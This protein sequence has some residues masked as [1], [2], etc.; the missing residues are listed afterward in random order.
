[1]FDLYC[2]ELSSWLISFRFG[3]V[4]YDIYFS[5]LAFLPIAYLLNLVITIF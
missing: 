2:L 1:M 3:I 5:F 4:V